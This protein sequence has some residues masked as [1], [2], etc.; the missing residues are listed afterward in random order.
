MPSL[1]GPQALYLYHLAAEVQAGGARPDFHLNMQWVEDARRIY[2][3]VAINVLT[4]RGGVV[5]RV[6]SHISVLEVSEAES[7]PSALHI[8]RATAALRQTAALH[9]LVIADGEPTYL[10]NDDD[11]PHRVLLYLHVR[12]QWFCTLHVVRQHLVSGLRVGRVRPRR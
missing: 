4:L 11:D 6:Q 5:E 12:S 3:E 10:L 8:R 1:T 7:A 9:E 2:A